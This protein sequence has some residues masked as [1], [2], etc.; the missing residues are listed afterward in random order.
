M[1]TILIERSTT[2]Q[3][4]YRHTTLLASR[5]SSLGFAVIWDRS[6]HPIRCYLQLF[7]INIT[8]CI[9]HLISDPIKN[10]N[11]MF[12][13]LVLLTPNSGGEG[14][15]EAPA[16][17]WSGSGAETFSSSTSSSTSSI[18]NPQ[19]SI[20]YLSKFLS[21]VQWEWFQ[22]SFHLN[23]NP[24]G[25]PRCLK[26]LKYRRSAISSSSYE[27]TAKWNSDRDFQSI[28]AASY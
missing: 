25:N 12:I 6:I 15:K 23:Q 11:Q 9:L 28:S 16:A 2:H 17:S 24:I 7:L 3:W 13:L 4:V 5:R 26:L 10:S 1:F 18:L 14:I 19:S 22:R 20:S 27:T 21:T 8:L